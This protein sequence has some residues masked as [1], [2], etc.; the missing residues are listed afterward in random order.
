MWTHITAQLN[1]P[2]LEQA[3]HWYRAQLGCKIA[4]RSE[5]GSYGAVYN[6]TTE[7]FFHEPKLEPGARRGGEGETS[8]AGTVLCIRVPDVEAVHARTREAGI[9][10]V[11]ELEDKPWQMREFEIEDPWGHRLRIGQSTLHPAAPS[12]TEPGTA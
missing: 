7:L 10:V 12:S 2:D 9:P 6:G 11:S 1:V 5:D 4:W 8:T 3:L